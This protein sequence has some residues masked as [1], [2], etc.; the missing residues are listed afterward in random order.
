VPPI[1]DI[2][3]NNITFLT[4]VLGL[5]IGLTLFLLYLLNMPIRALR[6]SINVMILGNFE[7]PIITGE[8]SDEIGGFPAT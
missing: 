8:R 3:S 6:N 7:A 4:L 1:G 2:I 5:V